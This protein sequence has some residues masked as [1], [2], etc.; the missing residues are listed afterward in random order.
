MLITL[1]TYLSS[2]DNTSLQEYISKNKIFIAKLIVLNVCMLLFGLAGEL[3]YI[4][5][6]TAIIVGFIPFVYYFKMIYDKYL[7]NNKENNKIYLYW[8][9]FIIW[10]FYGLAALLPYE[11]KNIAYN[12]LDLF[13]KNL[14]SV[15]LV[16]MILNLKK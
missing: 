3:N 5:Y 9:F 13:S 16:L 8:F 14:L 1:I 2:K 12:I 15:F 7:I 6:N 10:S 4:D 11:E